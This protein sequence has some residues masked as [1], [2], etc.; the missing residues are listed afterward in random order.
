[1]HLYS[2]ATIQSLINDTNPKNTFRRGIY[3]SITGGGGGPNPLFF[4]TD[5]HENRRHRANFGLFIRSIGLVTDSDWVVT[6]HTGG[7]LYR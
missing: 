7:G 6:V 3:T 1:M 2:Y 4:A 5:V